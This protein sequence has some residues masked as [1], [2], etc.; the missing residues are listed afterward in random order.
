M[1]VNAYIDGYNLY[2]AEK[3]LNDNRLKWVNL[4][5]LCQHF[6]DEDEI[7]DKVYYFTAY[8]E[9]HKSNP[10]KAYKIDNHKKYTDDF[11]SGF[12]VEKKLGSFNCAKKE[13]QTDINLALQLYEDAVYDRFDK[14]FLVT[15]DADFLAVIK[16]IRENRETKNK[17]IIILAPQKC[18]SANFEGADNI[19]Q[20]EKEH[21]AGHLLPKYGKNG[22]MMPIYNLLTTQS[23]KQSKLQIDNAT[24][25]SER[26]PFP[27]KEFVPCEKCK[28]YLSYESYEKISQ[29]INS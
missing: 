24:K 4:R 15:A 8:A 2:Y 14:A 6:C 22:V 23:E 26:I 12:G 29:N 11:L 21:F 1:R 9:Y 18:Q 16:K 20:L 17:Q 3:D 28:N 25:F 7:L 13:K 5:A 27:P 19:I 10:R